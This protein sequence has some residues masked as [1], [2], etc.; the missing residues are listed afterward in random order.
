M[1]CGVPGLLLPALHKLIFTNSHHSSGFCIATLAN[2]DENWK[3]QLQ[4]LF[5]VWRPARGN[6]ITIHP[7]SVALKELRYSNSEGEEIG[8][9][10]VASA[11]SEYLQ[12]SEI[13]YISRTCRSFFTDFLL[14]SVFSRK[15]CRFFVKYIKKFSLILLLVFFCLLVLI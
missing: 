13:L 11:V 4:L 3:R 10:A 15:C 7:I 2:N 5:R 1:E 9:S 8:K 6:T 12:N 14:Y